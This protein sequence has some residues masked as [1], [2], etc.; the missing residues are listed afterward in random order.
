MALKSLV[1][2][3]RSVAVI[4]HHYKNCLIEFVR[5]NLKRLVTITREQIKPLVLNNDF[6]KMHLFIY[7]AI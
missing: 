2:Q 1:V 4:H 3:Q 7:K 6:I 5:R